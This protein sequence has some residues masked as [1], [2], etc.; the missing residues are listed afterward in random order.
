MHLDFDDG[1]V[2]DKSRN[3]LSIYTENIIPY[4]GAAYFNGRARMLINRF[5]NMAFHGHL[6]IKFRYKEQ[7]SGLTSGAL[8]ALVT[9]GDCGEDPSIIVAKMPGYVLLGSKTGSA[10]TFAMPVVVSFVQLYS[11]PKV[12]HNL[13]VIFKDFQESYSYCC[14]TNLLV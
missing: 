8:Q 2:I 13:K 9:N 5:S 1:Q 10:R 4:R 7:L 6:V 11:S 3:H 12:K 14:K